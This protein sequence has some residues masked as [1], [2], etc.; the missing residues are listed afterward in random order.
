MGPPGMGRPS[1]AAQPPMVPAAE[2]QRLP[3]GLDGFCPVTLVEREKWVKGD[4]KYG[5][6][7]RGRTY[8]FA[9]PEEQAR[10]L[11]REGYDKY[12][13]ALS[14]YD[15]VTYAEQGALVD[16]KRVHGVFYRGQVFLF[17]DEVTLQHFWTAPER[18]ATAVRAEQ[19]RSAMRSGLQ[20]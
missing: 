15:A 2:Q 8:L 18:Y 9:G 3:L 4:P 17:A 7:H 12:A 6:C 16:G 5:A 19:Q 20:R 1:N 10:F 13:P 11:D 14:G